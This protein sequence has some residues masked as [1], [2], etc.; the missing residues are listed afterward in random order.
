PG[1]S[2]PLSS[3]RRDR[4]R[5][6]G[7]RKCCE[8]PDPSGANRAACGHDG[9]M[10]FHAVTLAG[11]SGTRLWPVSRAGNPK[12]LHPLTGSSATLLQATL[13]R[14]APLAGPADTY[15]VT[16]VAHA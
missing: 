11:G 6:S 2:D 14:L 10:R 9:R 7:G 3:F 1:R 13:D 15:V 8:P 4:R 16:G 5:G 12:F